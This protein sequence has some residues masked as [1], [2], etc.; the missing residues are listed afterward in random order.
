M[1]VI[2]PLP[3][4]VVGIEDEELD[5]AVV[6][7]LGMVA[8]QL[9]RVLELEDVEDPGPDEVLEDEVELE[10]RE[11]EVEDT[12]EEDE[13]DED[14]ELED[15]LLDEELEELDEEVVVVEDVGGTEEPIDDE[16][17]EDEL[18]EVVTA[19]D[20]VVDEE[21]V[22]DELVDDEVVDVDP[23]Q[24]YISSLSPAPQYSPGNPP[25]GMSHCESSTIT[26][27]LLIV[28]PQ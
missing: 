27:P 14:V 24:L 7:L 21:V 4:D 1:L 9:E 3:V 16:L 12:V 18:L 15:E 22:V 10:V 2:P 17:L 8:G 20:E 13:L 25:H 11:L 5:E 19:T 23:P 28:F 6:E 26:L